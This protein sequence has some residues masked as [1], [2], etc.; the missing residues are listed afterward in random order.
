M[1]PPGF[2]QIAPVTVHMSR[3]DFAEAVGAFRG[4]KNALADPPSGLPLL[5]LQKPAAYYAANLSG[6]Y[7][8]ARFGAP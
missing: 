7:S 4:A 6:Y 2:I 3:A 1:A 8:D 5:G